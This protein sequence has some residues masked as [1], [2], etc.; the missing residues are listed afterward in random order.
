MKDGI[1]KKVIVEHVTGCRNSGACN[2]MPKYNIIYPSSS[3]NIDN[4]SWKDKSEVSCAYLMTHCAKMAER[5][6]EVQLQYFSK[7]ATGWR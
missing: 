3:Y 6:A 5:R 1:G 4:I 7:S 2:G